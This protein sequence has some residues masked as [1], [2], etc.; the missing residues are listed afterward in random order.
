MI[1]ASRWRPDF[2]T[3]TLLVTNL[4]TYRAFHH[5]SLGA[6][7]R[8][9]ANLVTLKAQLCIAVERIVGI[10]PAEDAI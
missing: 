7:A 1:S 10:L 9:M 5:I 8:L 6:L 3:T 4:T 2:E